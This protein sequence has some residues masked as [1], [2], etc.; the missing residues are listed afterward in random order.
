MDSLIEQAEGGYCVPMGG[1]DSRRN[2]ITS[3]PGNQVASVP[4]T[5]ARVDPMVDLRY[6]QRNARCCRDIFG[7]VSGGSSCPAFTDAPL[8]TD[9][10]SFGNCANGR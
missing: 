7:S 3:A 4:S 2:G 5:A 6:E 8:R 10:G 1:S 9:H